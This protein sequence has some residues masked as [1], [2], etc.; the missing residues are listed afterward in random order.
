MKKLVALAIA[1]VST[2]AMFGGTAS[3]AQPAVQG[4]IGDYMSTNAR[5][6]EIGYNLY[7]GYGGPGH[8]TVDNLGEAVSFFATEVTYYGDT[9]GLGEEIQWLQTGVGQGHADYNPC[10]VP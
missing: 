4:C 9:P 2:A 8:E 10:Y 7:P 3:A 1:L 6:E 5:S